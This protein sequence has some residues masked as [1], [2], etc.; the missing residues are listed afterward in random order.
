MGLLVNLKNNYVKVIGFGF[1][2]AKHGSDEKHYLLIKNPSTPKNLS[3]IFMINLS[4]Y[5]QCFDFF[6]FFLR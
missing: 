2:K 4:E 1:E 3:Q 5:F 6:F